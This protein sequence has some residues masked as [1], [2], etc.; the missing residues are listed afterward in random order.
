[1]ADFASVFVGFT[2]ASGATLLVNQRAEIHQQE[3]RVHQTGKIL[4]RQLTLLRRDDSAARRAATI[5]ELGRY[6]AFHL[7]FWI[8]L[9]DGQLLVP[10]NLSDPPPPG[11]RPGGPDGH[12]PQPADAPRL[13]SCFP[14]APANG[15]LRRWREADRLLQVILHPIENADQ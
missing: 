2:L 14:P 1:M 10:D 9:A 15:R 12:G 4:S 5:Q 11:T 8:R 7:V 3:P 6:I 13:N